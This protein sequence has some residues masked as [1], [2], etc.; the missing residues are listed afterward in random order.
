MSNALLDATGVSFAY[1]DKPVLRDVRITLASGEVVAHS[2]RM[3][4]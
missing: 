3:D 4:P 2:L 1:G